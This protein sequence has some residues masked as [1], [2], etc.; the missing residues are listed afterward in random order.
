LLTKPG[1]AIKLFH[2][3]TFDSDA[4]ASKALAFSFP[5]LRAGIHR[6]HR[7]EAELTAIVSADYNQDD[8]AA[9][10]ATNILRKSEIRLA[11]TADLPKLAALAR[12]DLRA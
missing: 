4:A 11:T 3:L 6:E 1:S 8:D 12:K 5:E 7:A 10:F 9:R 2:A